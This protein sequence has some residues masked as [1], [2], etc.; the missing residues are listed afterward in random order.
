[1]SKTS[2]KQKTEFYLQTPP[3]VADTTSF[4]DA[5]KQIMETGKVS[6]LLCHSFDAYDLAKSWKTE[7]ALLLP[8]SEHIQKN[9]SVDGVHIFDRSI[10]LKTIRK[11]YKD[12]SI[13]FGPIGDKHDAMT[14]GE[15]GADYLAF[16]ATQ[17]ELLEWWAKHFVVPCVAWGVTDKNQAKQMVDLGVDFIMPAPLFWKDPIKNFEEIISVL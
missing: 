10:N 2:T 4:H 11:D 8:W 5:L 13:G 16:S 15:E 17:T 6:A 9:D 14:F 1:M 3:L 7:T 12:K